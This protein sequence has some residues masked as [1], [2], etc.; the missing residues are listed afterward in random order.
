MLEVIP[1][2]NCPDADCVGEKLARLE[3]LGNEW[4]HI[5]VADGKFT[6]YKTWADPA[7]LS[8]NFN[9]EVHLM[10]K[11]PEAAVDSWLEAGAKRIIVH[12]ETLDGADGGK[13]Q[14]I[15]EKCAGYDAEIMLASNPETAFE[16]LIPYFE[17]VFAFQCLA[18][19]PG[20]AGQVFGETT[21]EKV[22]FIRERMPEAL[23]EVDGGVNREVAKKVRKI[24][25]DIVTSSTYLF[26]S[27]NIKTAY[28]ELRNV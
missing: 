14:A 11:N 20:P 12:V 9:V 24:G 2:I 22:S 26:S 21:V 7:E 3:E 15:I 1:V 28:E 25:A 16:E 23:I 19:K 13:I 27:K 17:I 10:V 18:V 4:I 6:E 8:A 5:D